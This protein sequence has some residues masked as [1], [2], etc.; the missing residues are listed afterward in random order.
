MKEVVLPLK[1]WTKQPNASE[2]DNLLRLVSRLDA[3]IDFIFMA[4]AK[5]ESMHRDPES[6]YGD[7]RRHWGHFI[8]AFLR[9][10]LNH[11]E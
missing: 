1:A 7:L 9:E 11:E 8:H 2:V 5:A 6:Q 3:A 10:F 4:Y